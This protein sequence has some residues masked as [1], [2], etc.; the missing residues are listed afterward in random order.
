MPDALDGEMQEIDGTGDAPANE[1]PPTMLKDT[2][3][4]RF[5]WLTRETF[6]IHRREVHRK[7]K[8]K[9]SD[10]EDVRNSS[11][12]GQ[13]R[14]DKNSR[15]V[16]LSGETQTSDK[17]GADEDQSRRMTP[18]GAFRY[19]AEE[20]AKAAANLSGTFASLLLTPRGLSYLGWKL[21]CVD[22]A[23]GRSRRWTR[24]DGKHPRGVLI[25]ELNCGGRHA[26]VLDIFRR[27][28]ESYSILVVYRPNLSQMSCTDLLEIFRRI[29]EAQRLPKDEHLK[30]GLDLGIRRVTHL[31]S[32]G[33]HALSGVLGAVLEKMGEFS[34]PLGGNGS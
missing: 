10:P 4:I 30:R 17:E 2:H 15:H 21:N 25:A 13:A 19:T 1:F 32:K 28:N 33:Q 24:I 5:D 8:K 18:A 3:G 9:K 26:Y 27:P 16:G 23:D 14:G 11:Q 20:I 34:Q 6:L 22:Q 29:D 31:G 7:R 12:Q